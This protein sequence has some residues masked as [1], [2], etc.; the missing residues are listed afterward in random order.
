M[1]RLFYGWVVAGGAFVVLFFAYGSQY[2]FGVF[3]AAL[4]DEF[5]WSR[6]SLA[7]AFS[8]LFTAI[9][10]DFFGRERAGS[11]VGVRFA[12]AGSMAGVGPLIAGAIHDAWGSYAPAFTLA[13][14]LNVLGL[15]LLVLCRPPGAAPGAALLRSTPDDARLPA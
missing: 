6:A 5:G 11:L 10:G 12:L 9:V 3:F 14:G 4:L 15:G 13:A 7:G 2:A 8:T 1:A